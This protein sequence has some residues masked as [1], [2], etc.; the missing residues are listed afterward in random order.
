[1]VVDVGSG[2]DGTA[3][4]D[5]GDGSADDGGSLGG[6]LGGCG[7]AC[8]RDGAALVRSGPRVGAW[9]CRS[10]FGGPAASRR[11]VAGTRVE[12]VTK[13]V[14]VLPSG[15]IATEVSTAVLTSA[16]GSGGTASGPP[17]ASTDA[18][19]AITV[20]TTAPPAASSATVAYFFFGLGA[21]GPGGA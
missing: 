7:V 1:M 11:W 16:L 13:T 3:E 6:L 21:S 9:S 18:R 15:A 8:G 14:D 5:D 2:V 19:A 12:T 10:G 4:D 20:A 17:E